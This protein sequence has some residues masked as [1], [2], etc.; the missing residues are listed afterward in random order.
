MVDLALGRFSQ[1]GN[2]AGTG[3][4]L[5]LISTAQRARAAEIARRDGYIELAGVQDFQRQFAEATYL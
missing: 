4:R 2:A 1:I 5:A 3:A